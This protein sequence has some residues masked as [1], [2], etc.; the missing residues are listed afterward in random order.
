[1]IGQI[2]LLLGIFIVSGSKNAF[3]Y[4]RNYNANFLMILTLLVVISLYTIRYNI[5]WTFIPIAIV[6]L[7]QTVIFQS[8]DDK[9]I[10]LSEYFVSFFLR[11]PFFFVTDIYMILSTILL[12]DT[13]FKMP[14]N[15]SVGRNLIEKSDGTF[16]LITES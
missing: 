6:F 14:I 15:I 9:Q 11:V 4:S 10:H 8:N 3:Y 13:L 5:E 7:W 16:R 1:M 12:C 2:F